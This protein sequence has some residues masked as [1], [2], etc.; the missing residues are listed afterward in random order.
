LR[1]SVEKRQKEM[2]NQR[3]ILGKGL[4]AKDDSGDKTAFEKVRP[5]DMEMKDA[6][7]DEESDSMRRQRVSVLSSCCAKIGP[8][9]LPA[10]DLTSPEHGCPEIPRAVSK[11]LH[12][13]KDLLAFFI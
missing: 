7:E 2:E 13:R 1:K 4:L 11:H 10:L 3:L 6:L 12:H 5:Q 9:N 8:S